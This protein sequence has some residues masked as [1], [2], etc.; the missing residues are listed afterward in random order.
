M[1]KEERHFDWLNFLYGLGAAI[2]LIAALFKFLGWR[3]ADSLFIIG[4][5]GEAIIFLLSG[6][7]RTTIR[8][9]Y[10]WEKVF[11][12]LRNV[13]S[14]AAPPD[15]NVLKAT[16]EAQV[17]EIMESLIGLN[18]SVSHLNSATRKLSESIEKINN[19]YDDISLSTADY[20]KNL[21]QLKN[22]FS[23]SQKTID[24]MVNNTKA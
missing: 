9:N 15:I 2:I 7:E 8:K 12:Q 20:Q 14:D 1:E 24:Q 16:K 10:N 17:T 22:K 23:E 11:P 18:E 6:L 4:F 21:E 19:S 3:Y 5:V 13:K